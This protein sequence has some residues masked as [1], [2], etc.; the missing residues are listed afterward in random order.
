MVIISKTTLN[1]FGKSHADARTPLD[2]WHTTVKAADWNSHNDLVA[3]YPK[4]DF[5]GDNRYVFDIGGNKHRL[6]AMIF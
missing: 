3:D 6:V 2:T 4:A 5:V 1:E